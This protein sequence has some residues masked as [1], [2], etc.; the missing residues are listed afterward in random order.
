[1]NKK[2]YIIISIA[3]SLWGT[4]GLF[5]KTLFGFG[6]SPEI[7]VFYRLF[8]GFWI[9]L[10]YIILK[11]IS[12]LKIDKKGIIFT[13]L[14]GLISQA[15]YNLLYFQSIKHTTI[16]TAVVLLYTAPIYLTIF[17][18]ILYKEKISLTKIISLLLCFAGCFLT[19]TGGDFKLLS[20]NFFGIIMGLGA[21]LTYAMCTIL[22][23]AIV[24]SYN[25]YTIIVYSFLFAWIFLIPFSNPLNI[26]NY[27]M[28]LPLLLTLFAFGLFPSALAYILYISGLS[29]NIESSKAG[30]LCSLE[31]VVSILISFFI[32]NEP[33]NV[34]KFIGII[35]VLTSILL[36]QLNTDFNFF[37]KII[38]VRY[39][40]TE[41]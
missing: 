25:P 22:S 38:N 6:L 17:G 21:G 3:G 28:T 7:T 2:G 11:D 24:N 27:K 13:A 14:I 29:Y 4:L 15:I 16:A 39:S 9:I 8:I 35:F 23:K 31:I 19:A 40:N 30:I 12:L 18:R 34:I 10:L 1:M 37:K 32:F 26:I 41:K 36:I 5:G 33:I 20:I